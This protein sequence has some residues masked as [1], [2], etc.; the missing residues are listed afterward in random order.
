MSLDVR[1]S[2]EEFLQQIQ[3][4]EKE[5]LAYQLDSQRK[6]FAFDYMFD[7]LQK[8]SDHTDSD[9][10]EEDELGEDELGEEELDCLQEHSSKLDPEQTDQTT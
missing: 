3:E 7:R 10:S 6:E 9:D 5:Q 1:V 2:D 4:Y 8:D